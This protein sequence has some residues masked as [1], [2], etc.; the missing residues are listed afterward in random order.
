M[1]DSTSPTNGDSIDA[2]EPIVEKGRGIS[3]IWI[4]PIVAVIVGAGIGIDAIRNRGVHTVITLPTAEWI[5]AGKTKVR[6]LN[7]EV[8]TVDEVHMNTSGD[9]V[10]LHCSMIQSSKKYLTEGANFWL[11]YPRVGAGGISGLGTL[12]SG[13]YL[14]MQLGPTDA[15]PKR[16]YEALDRSPLESDVSP[17]LTI[18]L[19][20]EELNSLDVGSPVNYREIEVGKVER[21]E[22]AK[23]GG[24]VI[25]SLFFTPEYADLV[26]EDS[27]FWN[28]GGIQV[29]GS[30]THFEVEVES[31]DS[32][33]AGGIAFDSPRGEK[34][35]PAK[36]TSSFW[37]HP[38]KADVESY[39]FRYGG[40]RIYVEA[41]QLGSV[42]IG[43][44]VTYREIPVGAVISNELINDSKH[45]RIGINIQRRYATLVRSNS[46][47][48]NASGISATLGLKGLEV[49]TGSMA[50]ILAGGIGFATPDSAGQPVKAGSVFQLH[51]EV[52]DKW[53]EWSPMIWR[54]PPGEAPPGATEGGDAGGKSR[55]ARFFHHENKDEEASKKAG[56]P[57]KDSSQEAAHEEKRHGF[58][59]DL[60]HK[61]DKD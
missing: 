46:V 10:E 27:R 3:L 61:K 5:E 9:G 41:P 18:R 32:V 53:L 26:R 38:S 17:G 30:L 21:H 11:V 56:E 13:A 6:Y 14:A 15:K 55:I 35:D 1:T 4:I 37:L 45:V 48:W 52:K 43:D 60:F 51:D 20:T 31:L 16:L 29:S 34:S 42:V 57:N 12:V 23:D 36:K 44:Q 25:L 7:I 33:I 24:G 47:F 40:L 8:G 2:P 49:H 58:F 28:A 22:L 19:H 54:G 50:S 39:P 59:H